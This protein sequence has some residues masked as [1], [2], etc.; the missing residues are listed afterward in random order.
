MCWLHG[1]AGAGKSATMQTLCQRLQDEGRLGGTFFFKRGHT[2]RGNA[3]VLFATLAY[4]LALRDQG[5]K[6]PILQSV[7]NNP[8]VVGRGMDV[9][10]RKLMVE[11]YQSL[12]QQ[13]RLMA[14]P[15]RSLDN[16]VPLIL[17]IGLDECEGAHAQQN[18]L[19]L[20]GD[21]VRQHPST[22]RFLVASRPEPHI[23]EKLAESSLHE[24]YDSVNIQQA[25]EDVRLYF[26]AEFTRI[27]HEHSETMGNIPTP[28][29]SFDILEILVKKSSGYFIY[30][31]TVIKFIDD[32]NWR[33]TDRLKVVQNLAHDDS[34]L[35]FEAL[36]QLYTHILSGVPAQSR[37]KLCDILCVI[38]DFGLH[39][40][41]IEPLLDL[42][43]CDVRLTL[44]NLHS[45]LNIGSEDE[46]ITVH[47]ESFLD[48]L[49]DRRRSSTF[50]IGPDSEHRINVA[51]AV[52]RALSYQLNDPRVNIV[53]YAALV[54]KLHS[55]L[56]TFRFVG[57]YKISVLNT[58]PRLHL[59]RRLCPLFGL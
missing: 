35:P 30:A 49:H 34:C 15:C 18:I 29:P 26:H 42:R 47:H 43:S 57:S 53:W 24:L 56:L 39:L 16:T 45:V 11:P 12:V 4:Q 52:L 21:T 41:Y 9:Q 50:Y 31:S 20:I 27:H 17:L 2:T 54:C 40:R 32:K 51:C 14:K 22:F 28:W 48:F 37:A 36:D 8:S 46:A 19:S 58:S 1:P 10:L 5:L 55:L 3:K 13:Y 33:P 23:R 38:A 59:L 44:R 25:F 6:D 7:E